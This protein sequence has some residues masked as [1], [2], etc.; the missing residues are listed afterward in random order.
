MS[1]PFEA[2]LPHG[3]I[4]EI[5]PDIF[6]VTGCVTMKPFFRFSRNMIILRTPQE[7]SLC[8]VNTVRLDEAGLKDLD[9]LGTVEHVMKIGSF[10]GM[11]DPFYVQRYNARYWALPGQKHALDIEADV[12]M[13]EQSELPIPDA[14]LFCFQTSKKAEAIIRL[15]RE[16]GILIAC[17]A[18]QNWTHTREGFNLIS[19]L[20]M[21]L[22]G[23]IKPANVGPGWVKYCTPKA[24]DFERIKELSFKHVLSGHGDPL[25]DS[26]YEDFA[27][28]FARLYG[29]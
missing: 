16:G 6:M 29:I 9:A 28:T 11:D 12:I 23:F 1:D 13:N 19:K 21:R 10:H 4:R 14:S 27:R 18:L 22:M 17:D 7:R 25:E 3:P 8:L 20:M 5:F 2:A 24:E 26:A 15:D